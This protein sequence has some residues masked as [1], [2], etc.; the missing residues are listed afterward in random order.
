MNK[1]PSHSAQIVSA[2]QSVVGDSP[3]ALHEQVLA[4]GFKVP[5]IVSPFAYVSSHVFVAEGSIVM[6]DAVINAGARIVKN[7]I[8]NS[9]SLVEHGAVV[10]D[11]CHISTGAIVNGNATIGQG[12]FI[13][14]GSIIKQGVTLGDNCLVRMGLAIRYSYP[15][16]SKILSN[17][18]S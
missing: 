4:L 15:S 13:G 14:S 1:Q 10:A 11:H 7:C 12:G 6:H 2:I 17:Q 9:H 8:I 5:S 16:N 3:V 18:K